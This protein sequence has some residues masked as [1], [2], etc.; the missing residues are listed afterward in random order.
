MLAVES[1]AEALGVALRTEQGTIERGL[2]T[3]RGHAEQILPLIDAVLGEANVR[4]SQLDGIA[5]GV[6]PGT[7][8]GV[9]IAVAVAQ[10]LAYG[11][12]LPVVAITSLEALAFP[13]IEAGAD[14]VIACIDARMG[15]V[16]W[17]CFAR[18]PALGLRTLEPLQVTPAGRVR[19]PSAG[20]YRGIGRGFA[21]Y[22]E[23]AALAGI[24]LDARSV[25]ALPN[26]A[27]MARLGALRFAAGQ[28]LDP[29]DL[30]PEYVRD[31]VALTE[32][33]RR[34]AKHRAAK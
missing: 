1:S 8:T 5:A 2:E 10:G 21:A 20:P 22:P 13:A 26:A 16:Y 30:K 3:T 34:A 24:T 9:R 32:A 15:E 18:D 19:L 12:G 25:E 6:G 31:K 33:E 17:G 7:F 11:A 14:R 28:G 4:L 29:A 23:L 27:D